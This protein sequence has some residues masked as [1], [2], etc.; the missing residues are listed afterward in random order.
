MNGKHNNQPNHFSFFLPDHLVS[1]VTWRRDW[2]AY[3]TQL[4]NQQS[5]Q[6]VICP[7]CYW[8]NRVI[9]HRKVQSKDQWHW[10]VRVRVW[11][12]G[13]INETTITYIQSPNPWDRKRTLERQERK[14]RKRNRDLKTTSQETS[15]MGN[16]S[17]KVRQ[18]ITHPRVVLLETNA[19][20]E[21]LKW[22]C[23]REHLKQGKVRGILKPQVGDVTG[24]YATW[25]RPHNSVELWLRWTRWIWMERTPTYHWTRTLAS[26]RSSPSCRLTSSATRPTTRSCRS[27]TMTRS[28]WRWVARCCL[29][30]G[31]A[32]WSV[33]S[34]L[35]HPSLVYLLG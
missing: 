24:L 5:R 26:S 22:F 7:T 25:R 34:P 17:A 9:V 6:L 15:W 20:W 8:T 23:I 4:R 14:I 1:R 27:A 12:K 3:L 11:R 33:S 19:P 28:W 13:D 32:P 29:V 10:K 21:Y 16:L 35:C 18:A 2:L 31:C 30:A